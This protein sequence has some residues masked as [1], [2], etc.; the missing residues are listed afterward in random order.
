MNKVFNSFA[1][2]QVSVVLIGIALAASV[3]ASAKDC[4]LESNSLAVADCHSER[5]A[6]ADRNLNLVFGNA[7][8]SLSESERVKLR[9]AQ[10]AWLKFRDSS[11]AFVIEANKDARSYGNIRIADYKATFV[12][13]RILELKFLLSGPE[14]PIVVW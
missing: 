7:M 10:K 13:K 6:A 5:Y 14:G 11:F 2:S 4:S 3:T 12:E 1:K 8:K 9:E